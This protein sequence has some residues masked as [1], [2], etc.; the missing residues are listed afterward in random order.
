MHFHG[1][2][3][4]VDTRQVHCQRAVPTTTKCS[5]EH[6]ILST[7]T[8]F[9][10]IYLRKVSSPRKAS[11]ENVASRTL[12]KSNVTH[13]L[14]FSMRFYKQNGIYSS[15]TFP[16]VFFL[17]TARVMQST[18]LGMSF[19]PGVWEDIIDFA[20]CAG[21]WVEKCWMEYVEERHSHYF[22][23]RIQIEREIRA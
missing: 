4:T 5:N 16:F 12:P 10:A 21:E 22:D 1:N 3:M 19:N 15:K 17:V 9:Y 6:R 18:L 7:L 8:K 2:W 13:F 11:H 23:E 14:L 20:K